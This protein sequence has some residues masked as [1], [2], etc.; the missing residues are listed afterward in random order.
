MRITNCEKENILSYPQ[1]RA[2]EKS[3][4]KN[5]II[6]NHPVIYIGHIYQVLQPNGLRYSLNSIGHQDYLLVKKEI[7]LWRSEQ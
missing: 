5:A 3:V 2:K 6:N 4:L 1:V 7:D